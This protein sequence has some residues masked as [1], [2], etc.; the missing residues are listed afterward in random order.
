MKVIRVIQFD[1]SEREAILNAL[2]GHE[3]A[4]E[5]EGKGKYE[6][7][8]PVR[9]L[10][11]RVRQEEAFDLD[12]LRE[13]QRV[14]VLLMAEWRPF[15]T[16]EAWRKAGAPGG[17]DAV[18]GLARERRLA[19]KRAIEAENVVVAAIYKTQGTRIVSRRERMDA[20]A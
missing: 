7:S 12:A 19:I 17:D 1:G 5:E 16:A 10:A 11:S 6:R 14:L 2:Q 20:V 13:L 18:E 3:H 9:A 15:T 8:L 4:I